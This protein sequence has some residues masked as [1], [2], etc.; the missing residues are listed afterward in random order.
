MIYHSATLCIAG[1]DITGSS[2]ALFY[3]PMC[4]QLSKQLGCL[5]NY[6][7]VVAIFIN[8]ASNAFIIKPIY[9]KITVSGCS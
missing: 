4:P 7:W 1:Y 8:P 3:D 9:I 2:V 5:I 6:L